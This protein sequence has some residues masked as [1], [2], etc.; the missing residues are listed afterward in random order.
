[1]NTGSLPESG[2]AISRIIRPKRPTQ[3]ASIARSNSTS[4]LD[5]SGRE[6]RTSA[7]CANSEPSC[8]S[9][10]GWKTTVSSSGSTKR[11]NEK[12]ESRADGLLSGRGG[13][14]ERRLLRGCVKPFWGDVTRDKDLSSASTKGTLPEPS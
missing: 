9:T 11:R 1:M 13:A 10:M 2:T 6:Q 7:S 3:P 5:S 4:G 14:S 12:K 8:M